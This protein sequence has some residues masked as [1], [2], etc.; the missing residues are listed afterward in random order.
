MYLRKT[1]DSILSSDSGDTENLTVASFFANPPGWLT[2][3]LKVY[4]ENP[5]RH[6]GPL[7]SHVAAVVLGD[8]L[9]RDA[10]KEEV[11]RELERNN[12]RIK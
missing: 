10:V 11:K 4:R 6:F 2:T 7:C 5:D 12:N 9:R 3:Q 8:P 1:C